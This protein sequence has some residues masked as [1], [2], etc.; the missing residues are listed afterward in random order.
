MRLNPKEQ[1][2]D[3]IISM[4]MAITATVMIFAYGQLGWQSAILPVSWNKI[5]KKSE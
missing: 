3:R 5:L 1:E 2:N 4:L